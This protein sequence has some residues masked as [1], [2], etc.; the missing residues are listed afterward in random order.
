MKAQTWFNTARRSIRS[1][2][3]ALCILMCC[4]GCLQHKATFSSGYHIDDK[5]GIPM[6]LPSG[7]QELDSREFQSVTVTL[8]AGHAKAK[9]PMRGDC[10]IHG[11]VFSMRPGSGS[12]NSSWVIR[13]PGASGWVT[14]SG[15]TDLDAQW[16]L[17]V[18][19][20]ARLHDQGC[21]P[22]GLSTQFIRSAIAARI[23]IPANEVPIFMYSDQGERFVN[24]APGMEIR[25]Q[26]V[27]SIGKVT[28][29]GSVEPVLSTLVYDVSS[30][31]GGGVRLRRNRSQE[32]RQS[33]SFGSK[34]RELQSLD[35]RFA[36]TAVLRLFL[37]GLSENESKPDPILIGSSDT[38]QLDAVS[39]V[40][41]QRGH[42]TCIDRPGLACIEFPPG[43]ISLFSIVWVN[44]HKETCPFGAPLASLFLTLSPLRQTKALES[45]RV[46]RRLDRDHYAEIQISRTP[47]G[48]RQVLLL[49]G[50]R[51]EWKEEG[52]DK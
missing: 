43:S 1:G 19:D 35:H 26:Q 37:Q 12:G 24:L 39:D 45:I 44:G 29:A 15:E 31:H 5:S 8:P 50:D 27:L 28:G 23:P 30:D 7:L 16:R 40:A 47:E 2:V 52:G 20:L 46:M 36:G 42:D 22:S 3:A 32:G 51:I 13:S 38:A 4:S 11:A 21:F 10:A 14:A 48:A 41:W 25:I 34:D 9:T 49:P 6:L 18:R 33:V 17:F